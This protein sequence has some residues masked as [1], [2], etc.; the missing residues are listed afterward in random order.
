MNQDG[1]SEILP[2]PPSYTK[3]QVTLYP[4]PPPS[5][6]K[7]PVR[8]QKLL[9]K[10]LDSDVKTNIN[11]YLT[12]SD[13]ANIFSTKSMNNQSAILEM[14]K[15]KYM[16]YLS[17]E[18]NLEELKLR[19]YKLY[20]MYEIRELEK[21][22]FPS[23]FCFKSDFEPFYI[24]FRRIDKKTL[25]NYDM[26]YFNFYMK[27]DIDPTTIYERI[28]N[29]YSVKNTDLLKRIVNPIYMAKHNIKKDDVN[30]NNKD[31]IKK[32][33]HDYYIQIYEVLTEYK[34]SVGGRNKRKTRKTRKTKKNRKTKKDTHYM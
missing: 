13:I 28:M 25:L 34:K 5:Y 15:Y 6:T 1:V 7:E 8:N 16:H 9:L 24:L 14:L 3:E 27:K 23:D 30:I 20:R 10:N 26:F 29:S 32:F 31:F 22:V 21:I 12:S 2:P 19:T 33:E 17:E 18:K 11:S 4:P